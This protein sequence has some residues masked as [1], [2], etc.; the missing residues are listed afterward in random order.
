[1]VQLHQD[2]DPETGGTYTIKRWRVARLSRE[3]EV[4]EVELRPDNPS[5]APLRMSPADGEIRVIAEF[6]EI[7][8]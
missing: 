1:V 8:G 4:E 2:P 7:V 3:G 5:F 6:L